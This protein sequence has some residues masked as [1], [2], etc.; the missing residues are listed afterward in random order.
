MNGQQKSDPV[1]VAGKSANKAGPPDAERMEPRTGAEG[2]ARQSRTD[3]AQNRAAVSP[4]LARIRQAAENRKEERFTTLLHHIDV[5]LLEQAYYWL[6]R[7][8]APGVDGVT[9]AHYG[10]DLAGRLADL[11]ERVHRGSYRAQPSRRTYIPKPDGRQRPL[12]IA[13]LEDKI[14]QR[15]M[16]EVLNAIYEADFLGFSYGFRPGRGQH[17]ALDALAVGIGSQAVNWIVDAD[18]RSF[19]DSIDHEWLMRFV[20]HR[21]GDRRGLRLIRKWLKAGVVEDGVRQKVAKGTPQGAVISPLLAN[22]YLHYAYDL[23]VR[24]WRQRYAHGAMIVVRYADDMIV[25]F[26]HRTDAERFL[27][28][29]R[30]RLAKFALDLH[31]DKTRLIEFGRN[32]ARN[33][34]GRGAGKPETFDFLGFTHI[35]TRSRRGGFQLARHTRRDRSRAKLREIKEELR[36]RWHQDVDE[37]GRW[38]S[39]VMRGY[40]AY[41]AV[42]TNSRALAAFRHHVV[43]LWRRAL[44]RRSQKDRTTWA[45]I[46]RLA[47]R[48]LPRPVITH[49]WPSQRFTVKH[50]RWEPY[51]G[52]PHVRF[53]AGGAQ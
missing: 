22:I 32:A 28:E 26:E 4:G 18:I 16:V 49:P 10:E 29:L 12:G 1:I 41:Y 19:F 3:R 42:P 13:A 30:D 8:A 7:E 50:P 27:T 51:A 17:D 53:C 38:L 43:D 35:C 2:N 24:Q 52:I 48:H 23:W 6:K 9:W 46:A 47:A 25:G 15:A 36:R 21:I 14:V 20:E 33:R 40:F 11:H 5:A 31:P 34:A 39:M 45:D 37:Q 44:R